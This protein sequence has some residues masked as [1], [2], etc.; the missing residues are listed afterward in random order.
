MELLLALETVCRVQKFIFLKTFSG[1]RVVWRS[2]AW[3]RLG[4]EL[5]S[6]V[7]DVRD[8]SRVQYSL[9]LSLWLSREEASPWKTGSLSIC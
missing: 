2:M 3:K 8:S 1:L 7:G 4:G 6:G 5:E 9:Q